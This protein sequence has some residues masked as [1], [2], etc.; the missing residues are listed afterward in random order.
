V[1]VAVPS[2][3]PEVVALCERLMAAMPSRVLDASSRATSPDSPLTAA[4]GDPPIEVT[5][6]VAP[7]VPTGSD[8]F[9]VNGVGWSASP[10]SNGVVFTTIGRK[11]NVEAA[12]PNHYAP[13]A[14]ALTDLATPITTH[15]PIT[16]PC[17]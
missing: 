5:C 15:N 14:N 8:C 17:L 3:A 13:E 16:R 12:V 4:W 9:E 6:G 2:A 10:A 11:V 7:V 1:R